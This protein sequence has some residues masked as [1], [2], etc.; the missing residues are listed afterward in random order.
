MT[1]EAAVRDVPGHP[2]CPSARVLARLLPWALA[3]LLLF[4]YALLLAHFFAPAI[5]T[6]DAN[7]YW[8]QG[9]L[10]A[11]TGRTWFVPQSDVQYIGMH[12]LVTPAGRYYSRYPPGLAVPIAL[13]YRLAGPA[14]TVLINPVL[15]LLALL[16]MF[17][18]TRHLLGPWWG[19]LGLALL[20]ASPTFVQHSLQND[21]HM[22][23]TALLLWGL[24]LLLRWER[25]QR[26][27][28]LFLAGVVL[29]AIPTVRYPEALYALGVGG[30]L[31]VCLWRRPQAWPHA[32]IGLAGALV[33]TLPLLLR[34]QLAFG[35]F[36]RTAYSLTRE[37]TGFSW[38]YFQA[39]ATDYVQGL[40]ADGVGLFFG[41]GLAGMALLW[42][43]RD[44]RPCA[45]LLSFAVAP[46][47]LL[48][49]AY[50]WVP[51]GFGHEPA[52]M[53]FVLPTFACYYLAGLWLLDTVGTARS[54]AATATAAVLLAACHLVWGGFDIATQLPRQCASRQALAALT[55]ELRGRVP[56]GAVIVSSNPILQH[57][58]FVRLWKRR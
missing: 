33:P 53:R 56:P 39:H 16:A 29:G 28:D 24:W 32:L 47:T 50:Y 19:V 4:G 26:R 17:L 31:A 3:G 54:R 38:R 18:L 44:L 25:N 49:M 52:A 40:N 22:A 48:Y 30:L 57:L 2:S 42:C 21:S 55:R 41:L 6:P 14:A 13:V 23:V 7:G 35:A 1:T 15:A 12:W 8:A 43:R 9:S 11:L 37:Q 36:W 5:S 10:L 34:N 51:G 46:I 27:L 45:A 58:D 20:A